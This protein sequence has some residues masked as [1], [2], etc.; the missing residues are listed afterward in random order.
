MRMYVTA[1]GQRNCYTKANNRMLDTNFNFVVRMKRIRCDPGDWKL[2]DEPYFHCG[3]FYWFGLFCAYLQMLEISYN[4]IREL[5]KKSFVRY[6]NIRLLYMYEN[7]IRT[8]E[9]GTFAQLTSLEV[10]QYSSAEFGM[11]LA[12]ICAYPQFNSN[13]LSHGI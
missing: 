10:R 11:P 1:N 8:V 12:H 5:N 3:F 13:Q 4:R 2:R 6:T 7:M 9:E